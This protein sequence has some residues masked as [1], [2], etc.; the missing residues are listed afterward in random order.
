MSY[1]LSGTF[2]T[3]MR[4]T[5]GSTE[6]G[7]IFSS[8]YESDRRVTRFPT[9][10]F[11]MST[12]SAISTTG[13]QVSISTPLQFPM[14]PVPYL[15]SGCTFTKTFLV[16]ITLTTSPTYEP[17]CCNKPSS[18]RRSRTVVINVISCLMHTNRALR[19]Y[20]WSCN[21]F[22][23]LPVCVERLDLG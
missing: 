21:H 10:S 12:L 15:P 18:S 11:E 5:S 6:D 16:P 19:M 23:E 8:L 20:L 22:F 4:E 17:G 7:N 13:S 9:V 3:I 2:S 1:V 14:D